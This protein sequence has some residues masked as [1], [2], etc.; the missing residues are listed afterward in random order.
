MSKKPLTLKKIDELK[1]KYTLF[2]CLVIFILSLS[3]VIYHSIKNDTDYDRDHVSFGWFLAFS[4]ILAIVYLVTRYLNDMNKLNS[5]PLTRIYLSFS[6]LFMLFFIV[7]VVRITEIKETS[8]VK[9]KFPR[10]FARGLF[11][12]ISVLTGLG[13][14]FVFLPLIF[15]TRNIVTEIFEEFFWIPFLLIE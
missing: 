12:T 4:I 13:L 5:I 14:L 6:L 11:I 3:Y 8:T 9:S 15:S 1:L 2:V 7:S 10:T